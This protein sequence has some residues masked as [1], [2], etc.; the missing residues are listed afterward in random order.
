MDT[1]MT[2]L[3]PWELICRNDFVGGTYSN[4]GGLLSSKT[5]R[6]TKDNILYHFAI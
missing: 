5:L 1:I 3:S 2:S 6:S 4:G